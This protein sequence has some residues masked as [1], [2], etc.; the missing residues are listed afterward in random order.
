MHLAILASQHKTVKFTT[1]KISL[2][3]SHFNILVKCAYACV[4]IDTHTYTH[5]HANT[6]V[7]AYTCTH[8]SLV[9]GEVSCLFS[10]HQS[11][12]KLMVMSEDISS[13]GSKQ[14][15]VKTI[16]PPGKRLELKNSPKQFTVHK[17]F[18]DKKSVNIGEQNKLYPAQGTSR[19]V[20]PVTPPHHPEKSGLGAVKV[21]YQGMHC[22]ADLDD[23]DVVIEEETEFEIVGGNILRRQVVSPL[24]RHLSSAQPATI[25]NEGVLKYTSEQLKKLSLN[26]QQRQTTSPERPNQKQK[27]G[28]SKNKN[29]T[30]NPQNPVDRII[31]HI[32][33]GT[34]ILILMRGAPG[35]GKSHL[36]RHLVKTTVGG[37]YRK[38]IFSAD[39]YF[40]RRNGQYICDPTRL[41][42][43]HKWVR[44][45]VEDKMNKGELWEMQPYAV[46]AVNYGYVLELLEPL[47]SWRYMENKLAEKN[48]H[49]V[50][51]HKIRNMLQRFEPQ[52]TGKSVLALLNLSYHPSKKPPQPVAP[53]SHSARNEKKRE[54]RKKKDKNNV[55]TLQVNKSNGSN[56]EL[57]KRNELQ[58]LLTLY[59]AKKLQDH[60]EQLDSKTFNTKLS[61]GLTVEEM[62]T[63]A[64][65]SKNNKLKTDSQTQRLLE[66]FRVP[67]TKGSSPPN[68]ES[69][70]GNLQEAA[71]TFGLFGIGSNSSSEDESTEDDS[72]SDC[73]LICAEEEGTDW[74]DIDSSQVTLV[75]STEPH[76]SEEPAD[77]LDDD[78]RKSVLVSKA[79][80]TPNSNNLLEGLM[81]VSDPGHDADVVKYT[82]SNFRDNNIV[83]SDILQ[84]NTN[85]CKVPGFSLAHIS[86]LKTHI[87]TANGFQEINTSYSGMPEISTSQSIISEAGATCS[88]IPETSASHSNLPEMSALHSEI[89][90]ISV[91]NS[92]IPKTYDACSSMPENSAIHSGIS[93]ISGTNS[94]MLEITDTDNAMQEINTN[95]SGI[96]ET[97]VTNLGVSETGVTRKSMLENSASDSAILEMSA[98]NSAILKTSDTDSLMLE[99]SATHSGISNISATHSAISEISATNS[100][101]L[102]INDTDST[103]PE[104]NDTDSTLPEIN[105]TDSTMPESNDNDSTMPDINH[106]DSTL[107]GMNDDSTLPEINHTDSTMPES[108]DNDSTLPEINDTDSAIP[109]INDTDSAIPEINDTDSAIPEINDTDSAMPEI[110]TDRSDIPETNDIDIGMPY[111]S[112]NHSCM[113]EV[114]NPPN[115]IQG[116]ISTNN[117]FPDINSTNIDVPETTATHSDMKDFAVSYICVPE[118]IT[119]HTGI[120][121]TSIA[122]VSIPDVSI[123][124]SRMGEISASLKY[125]P[126][127]DTSSSIVLSVGAA[128]MGA[129]VLQSETSTESDQGSCKKYILM[130]SVPNVVVGVRESKGNDAPVASAIPIEISAS[131]SAESNSY[132]SGLL[133]V[134][135][136]LLEHCLTSDEMVSNCKN[137]YDTNNGL[138]SNVDKWPTLATIGSHIS[139][140]LKQTDNTHET[141]TLSENSM[142][143]SI[144]NCDILKSK[145]QSDSFENIDEC[146]NINVIS[147][148]LHG[149][150][151]T[152]EEMEHWIRQREQGVSNHNLCCVPQDSGATEN[153][154][155]ESNIAVTREDLVGVSSEPT[156]AKCD[157]LKTLQKT[158]VYDKVNEETM[159]KFLYSNSAREVDKC[160]LS[161][162]HSELTGS[163][164]VSSSVHS[165]EAV[166]SDQAVSI[167]AT[168]DNDAGN[169]CA[170]QTSILL[171][172]T[173]TIESNGATLP[174]VNV[175][176]KTSNEDLCVL[177][178][179]SDVDTSSCMAEEYEKV[180]E[181]ILLDAAKPE[182]DDVLHSWEHGTP[183]EGTD[184]TPVQTESSMDAG[185]PKPARRMKRE[186]VL[187]CTVLKATKLGESPL[188]GDFGDWQPVTDADVSWQLENRADFTS[189]ETLLSSEEPRPQREIFADDKSADRRFPKVCNNFNLLDKIDVCGSVCAPQFHERE[190]NDDSEYHH[191]QEEKILIDTSTCMQ[192]TDFWVAQLVENND[193]REEMGMLCGMKVLA[194]SGRYISNSLFPDLEHTRNVPTVLMLDKSSM[195]G[196]DSNCTALTD[197]NVARRSF[198]QLSTI[199][200]HIPRDQLKELFEKCKGDVNWTAEMLLDSGYE[201]QDTLQD[202]DI[203]VSN[204]VDDGRENQASSAPEGTMAEQFLYSLGTESPTTSTTLKSVETRTFT[205][206]KNGRNAFKTPP[207]AESLELK[208]HF[209]MNIHIDSSHY[210]EHV[211]RIKRI[212]HGELV[213][214]EEVTSTPR[215]P[216]AP[217]ADALDESEQVS[218]KTGTK[219]NV[220][221]S[222]NLNLGD[223]T[224]QQPIEE[225][226]EAA[227]QT[228]DEDQTEWLPMTLEH[229]F[230]NTLHT[231]FGNPAMPFPPDLAPVVNIPLSLARQLHCYL[232]DAQQ[233]HMEWQSMKD[234]ELAY[235]LQQEEHSEGSQVA[236]LQEIMDMEMALSLYR[237]DLVSLTA[238]SSPVMG[239]T[240]AQQLG[241]LPPSQTGSIRIGVTRTWELKQMMHSIVWFSLLH[242][243]FLPGVAPYSPNFV[244]HLLSRPHCLKS[245]PN[246]SPPLIYCARNYAA[247]CMKRL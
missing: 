43:A 13:H 101:M 88:G 184:T 194:S 178:Q 18:K 85:Y 236:D 125:K 49:G 105:H 3:K 46:L 59:F 201:P 30:L 154:S 134:N 34:R 51:R 148:D 159:L 100:T 97:S 196:D 155:Y 235:W 76:G 225:E 203:S 91:T 110:S 54:R 55:H 94:A 106:T 160:E 183:W 128:E 53:N 67:E 102:E 40:V 109:E 87:T 116:I 62:F 44:D 25:T 143:D 2:V 111:I 233:A 163:A 231:M 216:S 72:N 75:A 130:D 170:R 89:S 156:T 132:S 213:E 20:Y 222:G 166:V 56:L 117:V 129:S 157:G 15:P 198:E 189:L 108:N 33:N 149:H 153:R 5:M 21:A 247:F 104:I 60:G 84:N 137:K 152:N 31:T 223:V 139:V 147:G 121:E 240:V 39:D 112:A 204:D 185:L 151:I 195:T 190:R 8:F 220:T 218:L 237:A 28:Q 172:D 114:S 207:S 96:P 29:N 74:E 228:S 81:A 16:T 193:K 27:S 136:G 22:T 241:H 12:E 217:P 182:H 142:I 113:S 122:D 214:T 47:N 243:P 197:D 144:Y 36:A 141:C 173:N 229:Q 1:T 199:F 133:N 138:N 4:H 79:A 212:R 26:S 127:M 48:I 19:Q 86:L 239:A 57:Q 95:N 175:P 180:K 171:N 161:T 58:D 158:N 80:D 146:N 9:I 38:Y 150:C 168:T 246:L 174:L 162:W 177:E 66:E 42:E 11:A 99:I 210:S 209:E 124:H 191:D 118:I 50:L 82:Y 186:R 126:E 211:Q 73:D 208:K 32:K 63:T 24:P 93:E 230:V 188:L 41:S 167:Q 23:A 71:N 200:S 64:T 244:P 169:I 78:L 90:E 131:S 119:T 103:L 37:H 205:S 202:F 226:L 234:E 92:S 245:H 52:H 176:V 135:T 70:T 232:M 65:V 192:S 45:N 115:G 187:T 181:P 10:V 221:S 219:L 224:V 35:S 69:F 120:P 206:K 14:L 7:H 68:A 242:L 140:E 145:H 238:P 215:E 107:P 164:L 61:S 165:E 17:N 179:Q 98:T 227:E 83:Y 6:C 123:I 77:M